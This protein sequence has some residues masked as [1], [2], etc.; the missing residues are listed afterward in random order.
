[1]AIVSVNWNP[2]LPINVGV[3]RNGNS[4]IND[5]DSVSVEISISNL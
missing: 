4:L 1:M 3:L 5:S 2:S